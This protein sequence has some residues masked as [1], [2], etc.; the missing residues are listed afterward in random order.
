MT[1]AD[2]QPQ[3]SGRLTGGRFATGNQHAFQKGRSGNPAGR[4]KSITLSEAYRR[5]L[6]KVD[7]TDEHKRTFAEILAEQ[8]VLKA[9][10]G[11][12]SALKELAD[13]TEGKARQTITLT[14][15]RREQIEQ[16]VDRMIERAAAE[17]QTLTREEAVTA[18]AACVPEA[19]GLIH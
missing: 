6:A 1:T 16:A 11:D 5:E 7:P 19:S 2:K 4:P 8:T 3:N 18:L 10:G 14:T 12:I 15:D 17:G 9:K 13:R